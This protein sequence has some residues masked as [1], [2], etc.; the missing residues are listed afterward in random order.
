MARR[1]D[2]PDLRPAFSQWPWL[3]PKDIKFS[4]VP[5]G[6]AAF[7]KVPA[8][9]WPLGLQLLFESAGQLTTCV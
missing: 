6:L 2:P 9:G 7:S 4:D 8:L 3:L 5:N 1:S